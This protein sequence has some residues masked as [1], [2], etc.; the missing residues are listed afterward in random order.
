MLMIVMIVMLVMI[1]MTYNTCGATTWGRVTM[2]NQQLATAACV[3]HDIITITVDNTLLTLCSTCSRNCY[4]L[5]LLLRNR[6]AGAQVAV[7]TAAWDGMVV[8]FQTLTPGASA[9]VLRNRS[10][11]EDARAKSA[12]I[13]RAAKEAKEAKDKVRAAINEV[14]RL[15]VHGHCPQH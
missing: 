4:V 8:S 6:D 15:S 9:R 5:R 12:S 10:E 7:P 3:A 1:L 14:A 11:R 2:Q 13:R